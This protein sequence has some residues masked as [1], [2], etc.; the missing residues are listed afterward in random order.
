[1]LRAW[2]VFVYSWGAEGLKRVS[3]EGRKGFPPREDSRRLLCRRA[4]GGW[5][6][7]ISHLRVFSLVLQACNP[8]L[9]KQYIASRGRGELRFSWNKEGSDSEGSQRQ[10]EAPPLWPFGGPF[11][12]FPLLRPT[13]ALWGL[14]AFRSPCWGLVRPSVAFGGPSLPLWPRKQCPQRAGA[15]SEGVSRWI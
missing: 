11:Y 4:G 1:M 13:E 6:L 14:L 3:R 15:G 7:L 12:L 9:C 2:A 8:P 5:R 10:R